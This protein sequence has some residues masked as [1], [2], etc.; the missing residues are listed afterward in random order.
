VLN[1]KRC[2]LPAWET[3]LPHSH[4]A[5]VEVPIVVFFYIISLEVLSESSGTPVKSKTNKTVKSL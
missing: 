3:S 1:R 2:L 4:V 5:S